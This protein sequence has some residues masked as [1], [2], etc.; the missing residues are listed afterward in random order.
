[1]PMRYFELYKARGLSVDQFK[2]R[3]Q[4]IDAR[5]RQIEAEIPRIEAEVDLAKVDEFSAEHIMAEATDLRARWPKMTSE[6]R[7]Q[8]C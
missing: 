2:E 6:E 5:K 7:P 1:M 8:N 4:P 3:Y